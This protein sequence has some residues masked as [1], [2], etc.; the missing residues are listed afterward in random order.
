MDDSGSGA[1]DRALHDRKAGLK[2]A[3]LAVV[4]AGAS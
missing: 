1:D 4:L 3:M 2:R